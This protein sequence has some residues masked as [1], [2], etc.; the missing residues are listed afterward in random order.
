MSNIINEIL[1]TITGKLVE[2]MEH[3][4]RVVE[5]TDSKTGEQVGDLIP[6]FDFT[7]TLVNMF[8][9]TARDERTELAVNEA[10]SNSEEF[11]SIIK[12]VGYNRVS[13]GSA[14]MVIGA[15]IAAIDMYA[16]ETIS[17]KLKEKTFTIKDAEA[18]MEHNIKN[19]DTRTALQ[20]LKI[21]Q[22]AEEADME[23]DDEEYCGEELYQHIN[24]GEI[25]KETVY[26]MLENGDVTVTELMENVDAAIYDSIMAYT[27][28]VTRKKMKNKKKEKT[29][30]CG[31]CS[32]GD[33][34]EKKSLKDSTPEEILDRVL[35]GG[36]GHAILKLADELSQETEEDEFDRLMSRL[37]GK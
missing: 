28:E 16:E 23:Y 20:I 17:K 34:K 33:S 1:S 35:H 2:N 10:L 26:A 37:T 11:Q 18:L 13:V 32:C 25:P 5:M 30:S 21:V 6:P 19:L 14:L 15:V 4:K 29:C 8:S 24:S 31:S 9:M 3:V 12:G 22:E 27:S 7:F 36:L